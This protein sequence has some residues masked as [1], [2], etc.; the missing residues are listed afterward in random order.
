[1]QQKIYYSDKNNKYSHYCGLFVSLFQSSKHTQQQIKSLS[2]FTFYNIFLWIWP[3]LL[4][5]VYLFLRPVEPL[6]EVKILSLD[7]T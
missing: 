5:F 7:S 3:F 6:L 2:T 4:I 1:M